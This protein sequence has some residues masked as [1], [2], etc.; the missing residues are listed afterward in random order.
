MYVWRSLTKF[1]EQILKYTKKIN[2]NLYL[3]FETFV[4]FASLDSQIKLLGV[5][6]SISFY[7]KGGKTM[8]CPNAK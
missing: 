8:K 1:T 6:F 7:F 3:S 2:N 4:H 5:I